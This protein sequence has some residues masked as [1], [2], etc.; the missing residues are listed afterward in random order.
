MRQRVY[1][2]SIV[3]LSIV[4]LFVSLRHIFHNTI[5]VSPSGNDNNVGTQTQPVKT[6]QRG[7]NI[8]KPGDTIFVSPGVYRETVSLSI[9]NNSTKPIRLYASND[10][11]KQAIITGSEPS[12]SLL[13]K[14]C[15]DTGCAML[16]VE[17]R[18]HTYVTTLPWDEVPTIITETIQG[19]VTRQLTLA[20]SPNEQVTNPNKYHEFW[21]QASENS[22]ITTISDPHH[23]TNISSMK[24]GRTFIIDGADRCGTYMYVLPIKNHNQQSGSL[25]TEGV[26]GALTYGHQE[27]GISQYTSYYVENTAGLLDT[28]GEWYY[29]TKTKNLYLWPIGNDNPKQLA[30][31]IGKREVGITID[32]SHVAIDNISIQ[33]IN[34]HGYF[35]HPTGAVVLI[36]N[37]PIN[38]ISLHNIHVTHSGYGILAEPQKNGSI[39]DMAITD[40]DMN[41]LSKS[42]V[43]LI[44]SIDNDQSI[45]N[46]RIDQ[47]VIE[48]VGFPYGEA[49]VNVARVSDI[50]VTRQTIRNVASYGIHVSGYEKNQMTTKR[51][52]IARNTI[53]HACQNSSGC[54]ALKVFGGEFRD[55]MIKN[56]ILRDT[57]GWSHCIEARDNKEGFGIGVFISNASGITVAH[58]QSTNNSGPAFL[59]FTRQIPATDNIFYK[60][61]ASNSQVGI[62]LESS[63]G[64]IDTD[65]DAHA[66][67]HYNSVITRNILSHNETA[68][69]LDPASPQSLTVHGNTFINNA[70]ALIFQGTPVISPD[71]ISKLIPSWGR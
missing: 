20:R 40:I 45:S 26:I 43:S 12:S 4:S 67:R 32:R 41:T 31:E 46:V 51:V 9:N 38:S 19:G 3:F 14:P 34:D 1:W 35:D 54:A 36:P 6:I 22:T 49:A 59:G 61:T 65:A 52:L 69:S 55:T 23:L 53:E 50:H 68:L 66:N 44:G 24:G 63:E 60:N 71:D 21:W 42:A 33:N 48:R 16:P 11:D 56:N 10:N 37:T 64:D 57:Q 7:I 5:Y 39:R 17:S 25:E 70:T 15:S 27:Q 2:L 30:I 13:W 18:N 47:S 8:S 62:S 28:P 29:D 58:N